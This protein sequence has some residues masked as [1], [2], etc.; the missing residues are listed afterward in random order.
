M[1]NYMP[2]GQWK[3]THQEVTVDTCLDN[4]GVAKWD[5]LLMVP[6]EGPEP[7]TEIHYLAI[8]YINVYCRARLFAVL[9]YGRQEPSEADI[10]SSALRLHLKEV[11]FFGSEQ[12]V[13]LQVT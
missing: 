9:S 13:S 7:P 5:R 12:T 10:R 3:P 4:L 6:P 1:H 8:C 2:H 11:R